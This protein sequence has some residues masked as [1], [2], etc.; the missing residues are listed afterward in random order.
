MALPVV[1]NVPVGIQKASS[2]FSLTF[3]LIFK[4][5]HI[6]DFVGFYYYCGMIHLG[7]EVNLF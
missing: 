1:N 2:N 5:L 3:L 6:R 7:L 4:D